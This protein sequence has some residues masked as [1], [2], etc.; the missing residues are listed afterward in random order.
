M[1][2]SQRPNTRPGH[3][4]IDDPATSA[5]GSALA[6]PEPRAADRLLATVYDELHELACRELAREGP[7]HTLQP[8]ALV[9]EVYLKL[10]PQDRAVI[11][12]R[13]HFYA[14]AAIAMRRILTDHARTK[15]RDK[16]GGGRGRMDLDHAS[17][18]ADDSP[19]SDEVDLLALD[20]AL[21]R[22]ESLDARQARLVELR[23]FAGLPIEAAAE[24]LGISVATANRDWKL[25]K[26]WLYR[27]I[28][29]ETPPD[30]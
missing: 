26:I 14:L 15:G 8:T 1:S 6:T 18:L 30:G 5:P 23:Y 22:L 2:G 27:E 28:S 12:D 19:R 9:H 17:D 7:G 24:A 3:H 16:R 20:D 29:G 21:R 25:A 11:T 10:A 4:A 13:A